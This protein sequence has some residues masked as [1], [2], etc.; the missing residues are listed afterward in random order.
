MGVLL[1]TV[2]VASLLGSLH[3]VGMCGPLA[4]IAGGASH[5]QS[6][7]WQTTLT[8]NLGRLV[9]YTTVGVVFGSL[10][11]AL[12][13]GTDF[14]DW[15]QSATW[16]AGC[17]MIA[18]GG[19]AL[20]R[21]FGIRLQIPIQFSFIQKFIQFGYQKARLW[22]PKLRAGVIGL[23]SSLL[24]CGWLYTFALAAA[25]TGSPVWGGVVM[26]TFWVGT[27]PILVALMLG[28]QRLGANFQKQVP[29]LMASLV[30]GVGIL[31]IVCRAPVSI[32]TEPVVVTDRSQMV[33]QLQTVDHSQLPCCRGEHN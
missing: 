2:L 9:A 12:E 7:S 1:G 17:L 24:P 11:M 5:V 6:A 8:Y 20:A 10:G 25:G 33:E 31:T 32:G 27:L 23:L 30:I 19:V 4:L 3:C 22:D 18:V 26:A 13:L 15:Q 28:F 21:S 16:V 14:S 29:L